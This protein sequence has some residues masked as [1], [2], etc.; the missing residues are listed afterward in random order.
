MG[1]RRSLGLAAALFAVFGPVPAALWL[2]VLLAAHAA[3]SPDGLAD[4]ANVP[5]FCGIGYLVG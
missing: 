1:H 5:V 3:R 4:A 2:L